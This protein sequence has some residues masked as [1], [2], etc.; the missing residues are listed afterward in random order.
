[1]ALLLL[2]RSGSGVGVRGGGEEFYL[3]LVEGGG[4]LEEGGCVLVGYAYVPKQPSV[5]ES[6]L[7]VSAFSAR[8]IIT[9]NKVRGSVGGSVCRGCSYC[10]CFDGFFG[11]GAVG[12]NKT[13][14]A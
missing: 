14:G 1:M 3:E 12:H 11:G 2:V 10:S 8:S 9:A 13:T 5:L 4:G 6:L 7:G